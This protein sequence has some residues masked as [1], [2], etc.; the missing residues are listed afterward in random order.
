MAL[1]AI[2]RC[3]QFGLS[4][5]VHWGR[6]SLYFD[7]AIG[8][9]AYDYFFTRSGFG[10]DHR[11]NSSVFFIPFIPPGD[12]YSASGVSNSTPR[13]HLKQL[14][15]EFA[16]PRVEILDEV[17]TLMNQQLR[18]QRFLGVHVRRTDAVMGS[19]DRRVQPVSNFIDEA[20]RWI[21]RHA[22]WLVFLATDSED[23][24][25]DFKSRLG[26][27]VVVQNALRSHDG[28]SLHGHHDQGIQGSPFRKGREAL[29]DAVILSRCD[30]LVRCFS[31][32]TAYSLC[33][34]PSLPFLDLDKQ[35]L[36]VMRTRWLHE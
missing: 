25:F 1:N 26:S 27:K 31:F 4:G 19:E 12:T 32:L 33:L 23:V 3:E 13:Q 9:N 15:Y 16:S 5:K 7:P 6:R 2:Q 20:E 8:G 29:V 35:N 22:D 10:S 18:G 28:Q 30:F 24:V 14:I 17:Q 34:N 36:G 21:S 11:R